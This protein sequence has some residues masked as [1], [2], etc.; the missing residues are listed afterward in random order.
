MIFDA[1]K[2]AVRFLS[3]EMLASHQVGRGLGEGVESKP[4]G[5]PLSCECIGFYFQKLGL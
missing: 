1:K 2:G 5:L 3:P 4:L